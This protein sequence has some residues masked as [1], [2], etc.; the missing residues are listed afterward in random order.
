M[1][2]LF[3]SKSLDEYDVAIQRIVE[4][5]GM[6]FKLFFD[7]SRNSN[8][9]GG[10]GSQK[11]GGIKVFSTV[12]GWVQIEDYSSTDCPIVGEI[13][14]KDMYHFDEKSIESKLKK[15]LDKMSEYILK[16]F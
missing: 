14:N 1:K 9:L 2:T 13:R 15:G 3:E 8:S 12:N 16:V 6:R 7:I 4:H 11:E 5:N 10:Y